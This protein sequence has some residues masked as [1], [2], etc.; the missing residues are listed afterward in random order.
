MRRMLQLTPI[1][2]AEPEIGRWLDAL[3]QARALTLRAVDGLD[4][5]TLDWEGPDGGDNAI[6][7]LL[8]HLADVE[9]GWLYFDLRGTQPPPE[10]MADLPFSQDPQGDPRLHRVLGVPLEEHV[11]RLQRTRRVFLDELR[12]TTLEDWRR[13]R[14]PEREDYS[15]TPEWVLFHLVEHESGHAYQIRSIR[16][17]AARFL[18]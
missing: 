18:T 3:E 11:G 7:T 17:R 16:R 1:A 10:V 9:I 14:D 4:A 15:V 8:Y 2:G 5:R 13:A 6:G 12:G